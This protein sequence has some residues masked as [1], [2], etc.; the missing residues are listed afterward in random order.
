MMSRTAHLGPGPR[1]ERDTARLRP[2]ECVLSGV[3]DHDA[4]TVDTCITSALACHA[5]P[6]RRRPET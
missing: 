4:A 1:V 5:T 6:K 3:V 2:A